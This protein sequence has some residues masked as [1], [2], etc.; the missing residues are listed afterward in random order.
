MSGGNKYTI[1]VKEAFKPRGRQIIPVAT[2]V[3]VG[4]DNLPPPEAGGRGKT[5]QTRQ[6]IYAACPEETNISYVFER[7]VQAK[8]ASNNTSRDH[9][10]GWR[11]HGQRR[12]A[13]VFYLVEHHYLVRHRAAVVLFTKNARCS[14]FACF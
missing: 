5:K 11:R 10:W 13:S 12:R 6:K 1:R 2:M 8:G 14:F 9:G 3:G 7:G 4:V